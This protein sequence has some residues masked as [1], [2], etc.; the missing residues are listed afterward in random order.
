MLQDVHVSRSHAFAKGTYSNLR[1]QVRAYFSFCVHF[2]RN[3]LPADVVTIYAYVQFLSRSLKPPTI[4]N[5]LSGVKMLHI[6]H[7]LPDVFSDDYLLELEIRGIS[8]INP[9]VPQRARL[10]TPKILLVFHQLMD[11]SDS[12]HCSVWAC[13]LFLFFT[14]SRLGSMLPSSRS[15]Q[16]HKFLTRDR[17]NISVEGLL[18]TFLH[19]KTIQFGKRRLHIP[20]LRLDS[21]F[22]P[23]RAFLR[24]SSLS[25]DGAS[26]P[27][28]TFQKAG[29]A[30]FL[31]RS[32]FIRVFRQVLADGGVEGS[33]TFTG[34]SFR[35]GGAT[36]AF[37]AG[38]P[39]ELIQIC[40]DWVSDAYKT[41][42]EFSMGN[43]LEFAS[44][45]ALHLPR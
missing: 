43:K 35:R 18:V 42:L 9:H 28:F 24:A 27:A 21:V 6:F 16:S 7:G 25:S 30:C 38:V 32:L 44:R 40:G 15:S 36:W 45:F 37:Q 8:R 3:P 29:K 11:H 13:S 12:L 23:V 33:S 22:C 5:Y 34:H 14:L 20:L 19:T 10:I 17:V 39:G 26:G 31:T 41:Y 4:K 1:T 2:A